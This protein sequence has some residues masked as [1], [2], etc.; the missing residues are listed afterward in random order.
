M[1]KILYSALFTGLILFSG[2]AEDE[3]LAYL[4]ANPEKPTLQL[5]ENGEAYIISEA[6]GENNIA[7]KWSS[8]DFGMPTEITYKLQVDKDGGDFSN[9]IELGETTN[10]FISLKSSK[11]NGML[12]RAD[13]EAEKPVIVLL[14]VTASISSNIAPITSEVIETSFTL[15]KLADP[16]DDGSRIY[17]VGGA[18]PAGWNP[19]DAVEMLNIAPNVYRATTTFAVDRFRFLGQKDWSPVSYN[20][21]FFTGSVD[22]NFENARQADREDGDENL[23]FKGSPGEYTITVDLNTKSIILD[24][25]HTDD[26]SRIYI[27]GA[28]VPDAGWDPSKAIEMVNIA[29]NVY[30]A[31]TEFAVDRFRFLGQKDWSPISYNFPFFSGG[32]SANLENALQADR[33]DGDENLWFKGTAGKHIITV[34]L[35]NKTVEIY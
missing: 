23:W 17:M 29:P 5:P 7:F 20:F 3:N 13:F 31:I 30:Q 25:T 14:R 15:Y 10:N 33:E 35:D 9:P 16:N 11:L 28:G 1:K 18:V 19:G 2:C 8:A 32:V 4:S 34:D 22:N 12:G 24:A 6:T 21:P 27:V 26:N